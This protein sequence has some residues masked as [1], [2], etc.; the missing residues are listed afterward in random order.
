MVMASDVV[1]PHQMYLVRKV[2]IFGRRKK[3]F[4]IQLMIFVKV[5]VW[6]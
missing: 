5:M 1:V 2:D 3:C 6:N 4:G